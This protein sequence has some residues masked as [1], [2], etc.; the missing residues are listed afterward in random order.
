MGFLLGCG[1]LSYGQRSE[2][3]DLLNSY[4]LS[5]FPAVFLAKAVLLYKLKYKGIDC[6]KRKEK[7]KKV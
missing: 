5:S 4:L 2:C 6:K 1:R 7:V 3:A